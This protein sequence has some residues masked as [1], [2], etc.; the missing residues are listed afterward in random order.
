MQDDL[1]GIWKEFMPVILEQ[2]Q[3]VESAVQAVAAQTASDEVIRSGVSSAHKLAGSIGSFGLNEASTAASAIE[4]ALKA[5]GTIDAAKGRELVALAA[6][7]R[8]EIESA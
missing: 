6:G 1:A 7:L 4:R 8:K 2:V 5:P 3:A